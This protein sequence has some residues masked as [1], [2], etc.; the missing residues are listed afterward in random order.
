MWAQIEGETINV[1][2][3]S[4]EPAFSVE[5]RQL[6]SLLATRSRAGSLLRSGVER[7]WRRTTQIYVH[8]FMGMWR[9]WAAHAPGSRPE[10][11]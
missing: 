3:F 9:M 4:G 8:V 2:I 10:H 11:T 5:K 6:S 7:E 1:I